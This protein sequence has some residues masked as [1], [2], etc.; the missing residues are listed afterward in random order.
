MKSVYGDIITFI[1]DYV[2]DALSYYLNYPFIKPWRINFDI[3]YRCPL[4]CKMCGIWKIKPE[5]KNELSVE[6]IKRVVDDAYSWGIRHISFA[7]GETLVR[8]N[9][10]VKIIKYASKKPGM[11]VDLITNGIYLSRSLC[12]KLIASGVSK[13]SLSVDGA[14]EKTHDYIRG[15]GTFRKVIRAAKRLRKIRDEMSRKGLELEFTTVVMSY[16]FRELVDIFWLMRELGFD[17]I[18]YQ[19]V[20]LDNSFMSSFSP[21][22]YDNPIWIKGKDIDELE[23]IV[24]QLVLL[25]KK[26][27]RIRNTRRYLLTLPKYFR[28][29]EKFKTGKCMSGY[30]Y[31]NVNPY[32]N[33]NV[34]GYGPNL[35]VRDM[36]LEKIWKHKRYKMTRILIKRCKRPCLMLCYEK[37]NFM[38]IFEAWLEVRGWI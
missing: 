21:K 2:A 10:V 1:K 12:K 3:T 19:A 9:D 11:R 36:P 5:P 29:K 27:G 7:G 34:C 15:K 14:T 37:L 4:R 30:S 16:N 33:I 26:T 22:S 6:E 13:I 31:I 38:E 17:Y 32:G 28:E 20:T 8:A 35:N 25:K 18:N 23:R 24:K